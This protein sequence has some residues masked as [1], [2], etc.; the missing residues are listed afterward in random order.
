[1]SPSTLLSAFA[2]A[3]VSLSLANAQITGTFP[4]TPLASKTYEYPNGIVRYSTL[5]H[6]LPS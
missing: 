6:R 3:A 1:M 2:L 4:A 5:C